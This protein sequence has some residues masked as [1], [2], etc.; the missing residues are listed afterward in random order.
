[1][2]SLFFLAPLPLTTPRLTMA[3]TP[4]PTMAPTPAPYVRTYPPTQPPYVQA[5]PPHVQALPPQGTRNEGP[6]SCANITYCI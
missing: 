2:H 1:M 5:L 6:F 3:P 4:A